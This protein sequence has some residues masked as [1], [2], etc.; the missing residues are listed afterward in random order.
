MIPEDYNQD[1]DDTFIDKMLDNEEMFKA[2]ASMPDRA[3]MELVEDRR[4]KLFSFMFEQTDMTEIEVTNLVK[5]AEDVFLEYVEEEYDE[6]ILND[7]PEWLLRCE[8]QSIK[9]K[10]MHE[11]FKEEG[12][13]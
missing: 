2:M 7:L 9:L 6:H 5:D 8:A 3:N 10:H 4:S 12:L 11:R 1:P 13:I